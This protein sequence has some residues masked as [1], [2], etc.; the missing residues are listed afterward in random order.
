MGS[1][2]WSPKKLVCFRELPSLLAYSSTILSD[3][4]G[5]VEPL[6]KIR[7]DEFISWTLAYSSTILSDDYGRVGRTVEKD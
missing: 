5:R 4:Y 3:D 2:L 7:K 1:F 6:K